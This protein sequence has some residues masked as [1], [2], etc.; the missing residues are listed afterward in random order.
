MQSFVG[1]GIHLIFTI[2]ENV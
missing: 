2:E 1:D